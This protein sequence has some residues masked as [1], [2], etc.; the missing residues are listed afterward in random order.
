MTLS[1]LSIPIL[2]LIIVLAF[3]LRIYNLDKHGIFYDEK[4]SVLVSQGMAMEG[5]TQKNCFYTKGKT[6]FTP[7]EFWADKSL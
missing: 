1:R 5:N 7:K 2:L 3:S 4:A 6:T